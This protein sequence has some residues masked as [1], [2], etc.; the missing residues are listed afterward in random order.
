MLC[1]AGIPQAEA[2]PTEFPPSKVY[3]TAWGLTLS[4]DGGGFYNDL[5]R[6][7]LLGLNIGYD[8]EPYRR[9]MRRFYEEQSSCI[10]PKSIL[11]LIRTKDIDNS[12]GFIQ[13]IPIQKTF[14]AV[15]TPPGS[16]AVRGPQ[17]L[18]GKRVAYA[19]GAKVPEYLGA[20]GAFFIAVANEVDKA[21]MLLT[22][23]VDVMVGNLP[24]AGL[25]YSHLGSA[26]PPYD[27]SYRPFPAASSRVVCHDTPGNRA[28]MDQL[29][30]RLRSLHS[31]GDLKR[32]YEGYG[33]NAS[34]YLE[35]LDQD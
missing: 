23:R 34:L 16:P 22:G 20:D 9:A 27:P 13:S 28:F 35:Q 18:A 31:S 26:L 19:M 11:G 12:V 25:V 3:A 10:Y 8:I 5:G 29:N 2:E 14:V 6:Y 24:D 7:I 32:F 17:E 15:F 30:R 21:R 33:L 4:T 1:I